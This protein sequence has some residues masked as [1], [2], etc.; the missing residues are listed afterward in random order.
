[1]LFFLMIKQYSSVDLMLTAKSTARY[2]KISKNQEFA[3]YYLLGTLLITICVVIYNTYQG[4]K[5]YL[6]N[7]KKLSFK[8]ENNRGYKPHC[9][10]HLIMKL[11][12]KYKS[13]YYIKEIKLVYLKEIM[14]THQQFYPTLL[15]IQ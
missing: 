6:Y 11:L 10:V 13:I 3:E 9:I 12:L 4:E 7:P 8:Y 1:M 15:E 2:N 14:I 5:F